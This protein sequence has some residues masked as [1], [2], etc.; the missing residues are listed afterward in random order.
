MIMNRPNPSHR[1][2]AV[3]VLAMLLMSAIVGST[4]AFST[5][6]SDSTHQT[7][8][9]NG[10]I[11]ASLAADSSIER[12]LAIV[13]AGRVNQ[14]QD[15]TSTAINN[16]STSSPILNSTINAVSPSSNTLSWTRL[17]PRESVT[18]DYIST[19]YL[20]GAE[21]SMTFTANTTSGSLDV[22]WVAL[23]DNN[24]P[25]FTGRTFLVGNGTSISG[26]FSLLDVPYLFNLD[27]NSISASNI[28]PNSVFGL[29]VR[30]SAVQPPGI[31]TSQQLLDHT[32][33]QLTVTGGDAFPSR[34]LLTSTGKVGTSQVQKSVSVPWQLPASGVFNYVIFT[35]GTIIPK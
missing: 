19:D 14:R 12:G 7:T 10:Y 35:E 11:T 33:S 6:I 34:I 13:K 9:L 3:L 4:I 18:F 1:R 17:Q 23:D 25:M 30:L 32:L 21:Q 27:G 29:R 24:Q 2:S 5:V 15:D 22:S 20:T 26:T 8:T 16:L 31:L 28:L